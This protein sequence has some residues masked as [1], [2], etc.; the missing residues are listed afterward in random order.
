MVDD[1]NANDFR[2]GKR[3]IKNIAHEVT[4]RVT[5]DAA[6]RVMYQEEKRIKEK[7]RLAEIVANRAGR[8]TVKEDDLVVVEEI[9]DSNL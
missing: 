4:D 9:L 5:D 7:F 2:L 8:K 6:M 3:S 1:K